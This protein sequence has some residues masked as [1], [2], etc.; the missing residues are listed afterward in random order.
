MLYINCKQQLGFC[1]GG[2]LILAMVSK[3]G[4]E[5]KP[6]LAPELFQIH[7]RNY[8]SD[9]IRVLRRRKTTETC[10]AIE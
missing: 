2:V 3:E 4:R 1:R 8:V 7:V 9:V 10:E 5:F 6:W